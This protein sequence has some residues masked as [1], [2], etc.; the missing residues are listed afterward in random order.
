MTTRKASCCCGAC[1]IT[2]QG[3]PILNGICH[4]DNCKRRTGSAFGWSAYFPNDSI[5]AQEGD[6]TIYVVDPTDPER[7]KR[8]FCS[9]CGTTLYWRSAGESN[10]GIA[11]GCFVE[12]RPDEL[13]LTASD[14]K[15]VPWLDLPGHWAR[16]S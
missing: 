9:T 15:R 3:D 16:M 14:D 13:A 10:T 12:G 11:G 6:L 4:C 8:W 7:G 1:S 5:V 2:V